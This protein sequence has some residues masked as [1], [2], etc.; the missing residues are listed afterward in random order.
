MTLIR[1]YVLPAMKQP[2]F[3]WMAFLGVFIVVG[4]VAALMVFIKGLYITN[5][6]DLVP[7][8]LWISIDLSAIALAACAFSVSALAYL[9]R[10]ESLKPVAKTAVFVGFVGY[11]MAMMMLLLDIGRP[12][13]FWHGFVFWNIH[14]A[15]WE[16]TICVGLYFTV[17]MMEV[18]P[19]IGHWDV[20]EQRFPKISHSLG[21]LHKLTPVLAVIGLGL[22]TLHQSSLGLTYGKLVAKPIWYRPWPMAINFYIS[23]IVGGIALVTFISLF[24]A[25]L[26]PRARIDKAVLAR[27]A[28][29]VGWGVLFLFAV[30][31]WDLMSSMPAG[32]VPGKTEA[33]YILTRGRLAFSFWG[34]EIVLGM[35][36]PAILLLVP[37]FRGNERVRMVALALIA[38]GVIAYRWN[39][40]LVGQLVVFGTVAGSDIPVF[41]HY[42]PS[43]VEILTGVGVIAYGLLAITFG[44]RFLNVIDHGE[45]VEAPAETSVP[46]AMVPSSR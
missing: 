22:S 39:T 14:S 35:I 11:S 5:L 40:N 23:A 31:W 9:A 37:R 44:V 12:D 46:A 43:L 33:L 15:L 19:I 2:V 36:L 7:W 21:S 28:Y 29:G 10:R 8:G 27:M 25:R 1:R 18:L 20:V 6:S 30:R 26:T 38:M 13:R 32:Y 42:M 4:V 24:A 16:V 41:T 45:V 17:L 34:L 3:Q